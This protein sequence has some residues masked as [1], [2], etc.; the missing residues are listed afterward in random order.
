MQS[1]DPT[2]YKH[3][4]KYEYDAAIDCATEAGEY[5]ESIGKSDLAEY[6]KEE[7]ETLLLVICSNFARK[8]A[9][10]F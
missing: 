3:L 5:I 7:F 10:P 4:L 8:T 9:I 2:E 6:T 1:R